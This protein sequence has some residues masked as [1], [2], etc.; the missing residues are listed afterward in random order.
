MMVVTATT[1]A[2]LDSKLSTLAENRMRCA[3]T[4]RILSA[5]LSELHAHALKWTMNAVMDTK[6]QRPEG[7]AKKSTKA[8]KIGTR[9]TKTCRLKT[10]KMK[11]AKSL[12]SM[13]LVRGTVKC[14]GTFAVVDSNSNPKRSSATWADI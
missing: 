4:V 12:A 2:S 1:N 3:S 11:S 5:L 10:S 6:E 14:L 7:L 8:T 9:L 13:R